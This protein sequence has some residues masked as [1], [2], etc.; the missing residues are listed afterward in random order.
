MHATNEFGTHGS[1]ARLSSTL[2]PSAAFKRW[3]NRCV[4]GVFVFIGIRLALAHE[5]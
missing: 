5:R 1:T 2:A 4:G 3:F